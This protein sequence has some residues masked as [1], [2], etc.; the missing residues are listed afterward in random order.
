MH[1]EEKNNIKNIIFDIIGTIIGAFIM[2]IGVSLFLLPNQLSSGG[3]AGIATITYYLFNI[4]MGTMILIINVPLFLLSIYKIGK[5]FFI[6]SLIGTV[7]LSVFIDIL[8]R[9]EPLTHDRFL[10]CVYG[11]III[12]LGTAIILKVNSSTGGTDLI[13]YVAKEYKPT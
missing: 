10:A 7:S 2:A 6:K 11:G 8:D 3:I 13:S 4:P 9:I 12:G 1:I 5:M